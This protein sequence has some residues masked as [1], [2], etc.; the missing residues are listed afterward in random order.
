MFFTTDYTIKTI[1]RTIAFDANHEEI[2]LLS[3]RIIEKHREKYNYIHFGLVQIVAKSLTREGLDTS[4][5]LCLR[6]CRFIEF[7]DSLLGMAEASL[8][9]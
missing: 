5:L 2:K 6:D 7:N 4:L 9:G 3:K 1:Q 8:Y